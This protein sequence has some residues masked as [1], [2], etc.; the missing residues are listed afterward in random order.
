MPLERKKDAWRISYTNKSCRYICSFEYG[1]G[2]EGAAPYVEARYGDVNQQYNDVF[3]I[4]SKTLGN[5][6]TK[7]PDSQIPNPQSLALVQSAGKRQNEGKKAE[8]RE[9]IPLGGKEREEMFSKIREEVS[10]L[11]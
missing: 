3:D 10:W 9:W 2:A 8:R 11:V 6:F 1:A 4:N 5:S 7:L